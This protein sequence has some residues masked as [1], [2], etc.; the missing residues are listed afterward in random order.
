M[1]YAVISLEANFLTWVVS[2]PRCFRPSRL[3]LCNR[4]HVGNARLL[5]SCVLQF[6]SDSASLVPHFALG[7]PLRILPFSYSQTYASC[8]SCRRNRPLLAE[9]P[10]PVLHKVCISLFPAA[11]NE[12]MARAETLVSS[13]LRFKSHSFVFT[14]S[15]VRL[16]GYISFS[17]ILFKS[18]FP[19]SI[20]HRTLPR[21]IH[22][23]S[24]LSI[25]TLL[26]LP[27]D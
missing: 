1:I 5:F 14:P 16:G 7:V 26:D 22:Y 10:Q 4:S 15:R 24:L 8:P 2:Q 21:P 27:V 18:F 20:V 19:Y 25:N 3:V 9:N 12:S 13:K 23:P 11:Y 17:T 6:T